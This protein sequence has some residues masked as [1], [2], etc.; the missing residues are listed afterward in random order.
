MRFL[1]VPERKRMDRK[2]LKKSLKSLKLK[3][4]LLTTEKT[5]VNMYECAAQ[6][7]KSLQFC[8]TEAGE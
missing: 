1:Q 4:K 5:G 8:S 7:G 6:W 2:K 3:K